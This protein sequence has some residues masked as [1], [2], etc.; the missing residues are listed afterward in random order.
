MH[1]P[2]GSRFGERDGDAPQF[3][4]GVLFEG[5]A[6]YLYTGF[7]P[8]ADTKR[9]GSMVTVLEPDMLTVRT[10]PVTVAPSAPYAAGTSFGN[11]YADRYY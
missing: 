11:Q 8:P 7:C 9:R 4:P 1:H 6:V 2:D 3:D 10:E 5:N